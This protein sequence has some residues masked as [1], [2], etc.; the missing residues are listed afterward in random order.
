M[1]HYKD[2]P[3]GGWLLLAS[4]TPLLKAVSEGWSQK[5]FD[6]ALAKRS[7]RRLAWP[8]FPF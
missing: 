2:P 3:L 4:S 5:Q 6:Q 8:W 1:W 7:S